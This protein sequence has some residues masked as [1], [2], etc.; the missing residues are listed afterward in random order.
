MPS[1]QNITTPTSSTRPSL[2]IPRSATGSP[3]PNA[4]PPSPLAPTSAAPGAA[5]RNRAALREYYNLQNRK[6]AASTP[7]PSVEVTDPLGA[8]HEASDVPA[9]EMDGEGFDAEAFVQKALA[10]NSMEELLR[11]Y[12]RTLGEIRAL[13]AEKK[14]LVYDNYSRLITAT[15]T[16]RKVGHSGGQRPGTRR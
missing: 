9:S 14:A 4:G 3:N 2:D 6:P 15:E 11:L 8:Q 13:D 12:T 10:E 5:K 7:P 1:F 16:I